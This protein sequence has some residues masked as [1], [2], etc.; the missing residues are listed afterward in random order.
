LQTTAPD[1]VTPSSGPGSLSALV[2]LIETARPSAVSCEIVYDDPSVGLPLTASTSLSYDGA[3]GSLSYSYDK[4]N[5]IG[6]PSFFSVVSGNVTGDL[7]A[8]SAALSGAGGW[9]WDA[10]VGVSLPELGLSTENM[11]IYSISQ[12]GD[13]YCLTATPAEGK[14]GALVGLSLE[15][16]ENLTLEIKFSTDTVS[17]LKMTYTLD[18]ATYSVTAAFTY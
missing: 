3:S 17:L 11:A 5:P 14:V 10:T 15:G 9:V 12:D 1:N 2:E 6:S 8:L 18:S 16:T 7:Q 13:T 4:P